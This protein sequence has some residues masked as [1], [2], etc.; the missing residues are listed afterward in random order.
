[1]NTVSVAQAINCIISKEDGGFGNREYGLGG[2][3]GTGFVYAFVFYNNSGASTTVLNSTA[4]QS[5][6][7]WNHLVATWD[8]TTMKFYINN[9]TPDTNS[10]ANPTTIASTSTFVIG[11]DSDGTFLS[12]A[13]D[14]LVDQV[15][16]W[17]GRVLT[18]GD[19][20]LLFNSGAGLSYAAMA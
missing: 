16:L 10:P 13:G 20:S 9:G 19:V 1:M 8:G 14:A 4:T 6:S 11:K 18:A 12:S 3:F 2:Q 15:G 17:K 5:S 7:A